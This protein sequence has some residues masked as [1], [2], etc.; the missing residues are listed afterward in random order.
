MSKLTLKAVK[1]FAESKQKRV[2]FSRQLN[3]Y[4]VVSNSRMNVSDVVRAWHNEKGQIVL[5]QSELA[6]LKS[7]I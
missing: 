4:I 7:Y 5:T 1:E 3:G 2:L 6:T